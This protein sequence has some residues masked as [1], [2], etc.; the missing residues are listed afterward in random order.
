[1]SAAESPV[2]VYNTQENDVS[3]RVL[4]LSDKLTSKMTS[5]LI[6]VWPRLKCSWPF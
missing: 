1:M 3:A 6:A 5:Q 4:G 2:V